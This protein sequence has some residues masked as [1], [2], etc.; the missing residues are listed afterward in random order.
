MNNAAHW[1]AAVWANTVLP[2]FISSHNPS[3]LHSRSVSARVVRG[4]AD[5]VV[6]RYLLRKH[7]FSGKQPH[8]TSPIVQAVLT[9][10]NDNTNKN[11][12]AAPD[13]SLLTGSFVRPFVL[14]IAP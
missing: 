12:I 8:A 14:P 4:S 11:I 3:I 1:P 2:Q 6:D 13:S 10:T 5:A 9:T 7:L